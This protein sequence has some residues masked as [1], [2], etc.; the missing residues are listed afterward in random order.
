MGL[1]RNFTH[2]FLFV[3]YLKLPLRSRLQTSLTAQL[4]RVRMYKPH[5][6]KTEWQLTV[7]VFLERV[8]NEHLNSQNIAHFSVLLRF[9]PT[10]AC[11]P[12]AF[13]CFWARTA[14]R[15]R[16]ILFQCSGLS[17][18]LHT[19]QMILL[20]ASKPSSIA[21]RHSS[22]NCRLC[23]YSSITSCSGRDIYA[24]ISSGVCYKLNT[25]LRHRRSCWLDAGTSF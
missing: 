2:K 22:S 6:Q 21:L 18:F 15:E 23:S 24:Y 13:A 11:L 14:V 8:Y 1:K 16:R 20:L 3:A 17:Y 25:A 10:A 9:T 12:T 4:T 7:R 19:G 5:W